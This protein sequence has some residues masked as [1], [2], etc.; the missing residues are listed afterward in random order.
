MKFTLA[1]LTQ[2]IAIKDEGLQLPAQID[3]YG[4]DDAT[5]ALATNSPSAESIEALADLTDEQRWDIVLY[6]TIEEDACADSE[7]WDAAYEDACGGD[8]VPE[9]CT[10]VAEF[11]EDVET[12]LGDDG[13]DQSATSSDD[14]KGTTFEHSW[15]SSEVDDYALAQLSGD[16]HEDKQTMLS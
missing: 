13:N 12:I 16:A 2:A 7:E 3:L 11:F 10:V 4:L 14:D 15:K 9:A 8:G 1:L 5:L 6:C